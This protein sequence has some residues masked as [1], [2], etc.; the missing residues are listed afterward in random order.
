MSPIK[1][2]LGTLSLIALMSPVALH[3]AGGK[4][5]VDPCASQSFSAFADPTLPDLP[6]NPIMPCPEPPPRAEM[7]D[8]TP[9]KFSR[10]RRITKPFVISAPGVYDFGH[11]LMEW[12]GSEQCKP[13]RDAVPGIEV[14]VSNVTIKN[15]GLSGAPG[16][17][18]IYGVN[19]TLDN[20]TAW[21]CGEALSSVGDSGRI[22]LK[23]SRFYGNPNFTDTLVN[24][25]VGNF[26]VENTLFVDSETCLQFGGGQDAKILTSDFVGCKTSI[27]GNTLN[28][29][30]FSTMETVRNESWLS[31]TFLHLIGHVRGT[32]RSDL[33]YDGAKK[34]LEKDAQLIETE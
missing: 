1:T 28:N 21:S 16:G 4:L 22:F 27:L 14:R 24:F 7:P 2:V 30:R 18:K 33:V 6:E 5:P 13:S 11:E 20:V 3:A 26:S 12:A 19:V 15:L 29:R 34:K 17:I 9:P 10:V 32:S 31:E 23:N 8:L 25:G